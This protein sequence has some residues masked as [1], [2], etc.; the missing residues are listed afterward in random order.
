[1]RAMITCCL[2]L[3]ALICHYATLPQELRDAV[4]IELL[5][6]FTRWRR[7]MSVTPAART[8]RRGSGASVDEQFERERAYMVLFMSGAQERGAEADGADISA[9]ALCSLLLPAFHA[10]PPIE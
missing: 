2:M 4:A 3:P 7:H 1:M 5:I 6:R 10:I 9:C 8:A